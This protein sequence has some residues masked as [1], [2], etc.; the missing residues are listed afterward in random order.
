MIE[1]DLTKDRVI[2]I[3]D[4]HITRYN[5]EIDYT[6]VDEKLLDRNVDPSTFPHANIKWLR[7]HRDMCKHYNLILE[8]I[9]AEMIEVV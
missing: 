3:L 9:K 2:S 4:A 6:Y 1:E 5:L 8:N 7:K